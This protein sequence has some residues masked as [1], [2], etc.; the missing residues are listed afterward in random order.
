MYQYPFS[1]FPAIETG[2]I[3]IR[4]KLF[5]ACNKELREIYGE[6]FFSGDSLYGTKEYENSS[7]VKVSLYL[8]GKT[9]YTLKFQKLTKKK[10]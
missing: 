1:V 10:K 8:K 9:E 5:K 4:Q 2:D 6:W 3:R 7:I